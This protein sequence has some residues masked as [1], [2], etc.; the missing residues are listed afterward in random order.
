MASNSKS[1]GMLMR[2]AG[3]FNPVLVQAVGLCPVVA[4][5]TSVSSAALLAAVSAV[6]ITVSE[7][8][9]SLFLKAIPRWIRIGIYIILGAA[10]VSPLMILIERTNNPLFSS[11]GIYLPIMAV[12]SLNV[13]RCERFAVKISP[14][15]ALVDGLTASVGYAAV[16]LVCGFI[17]ETLGNGS[18]FGLEIFKG[19]TMTGL[20]LPFG[21]F[22]ILGFAGAALRALIAKFWPKYLDKKQPKPGSKKKAHNPVS[23]DKNASD[24]PASRH[25]PEFTA[26]ESTFT[27][28]ELDKD[29]E[30]QTQTPAA[31]ASKAE[32][33]PFKQAEAEQNSSEEVIQETSAENDKNDETAENISESAEAVH[34]D[35][36]FADLTIDDISSDTEIADYSDSD[37]DLEELMNRSI[38]DILTKSKKEEEE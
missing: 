2:N 20:L 18:L 7:L 16:L 38:G 11:L 34:E 37:D 1:P 35:T 6:I 3:I 8:I 12:N 25:I 27:L 33:S 28:E 36:A 17:R 15:K 29:P 31:E 23:L 13:L 30:E 19:R 4:M 24:K 21:G 26:D 14:I 22:L 10:I 5:A 9:A 32:D